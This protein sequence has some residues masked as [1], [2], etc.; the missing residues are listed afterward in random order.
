LNTLRTNGLSSHWC[1]TRPSSVMYA[2]R[3][4][5]PSLV[6]DS[7]PTSSRGSGQLK[8]LLPPWGCKP[9]QLLCPFS[10]SSIRDPALSLIAGCKHKPLYLSGSGRASQETTVWGFGQQALPSIHNSV[11]VWWLYKGYIPKWGSL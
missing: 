6:G 5:G 11:L 3:A 10:N 8:Q 7:V 4:M 1:P 2:P 9:P